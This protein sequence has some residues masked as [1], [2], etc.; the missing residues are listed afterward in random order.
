MNISKC[1]LKFRPNPMFR[2]TWDWDEILRIP[3]TFSAIAHKNSYAF[4]S[5]IDCASGI[6]HTL[7]MESNS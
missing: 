3:S 5:N 4:A 2:R 7:C 1:F 6:D